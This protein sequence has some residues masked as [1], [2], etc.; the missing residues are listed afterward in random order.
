MRTEADKA[1]EKKAAEKKKAAEEL[2]KKIEEEKKAAEAA[3][4]EQ[5]AEEGGVRRVPAPP[6]YIPEVLGED[7]AWRRYLSQYL[8]RG[9]VED[10]MTLLYSY[11]T[12]AQFNDAQAAAAVRVFAQGGAKRLQHL[13]SIQP[14]ERPLLRPYLAL[15]LGDALWREQDGIGAQQMW[16]QAAKESGWTPLQREARK[17]LNPPEG[18]PA[19]T[20]GLLLPLSGKYEALGRNLLHAAQLAQR[21]YADAGIGLLIRDTAGDVQAAQAAATE[22]IEAGVDAIVGPLFHDPARAAVELAVNSAIPIMPLNPRP[23]LT[24]F[25]DDNPETQRLLYQ[26][27]FNAEQQA[28]DMARY[29]IE[30]DKRR[31]VAIL[32]P[33]S[34]QGRM[35]AEAF[36]DEAK[37][38]GAGVVGPDYFPRDTRDFS[39]W[40][41]QLGH[42]DKE[43]IARRMRTARKA[44]A[45]DPADS[46]QTEEVDDIPPWYAFDALYLPGSAAHGRL[47]APQLAFYD[48]HIPQTAL[49]GAVGWNSPHLL[50]AGAEYLKGAVFPDA[51]EARAGAFH[52]AYSKAWG[53]RPSNLAALAYDAVAVAAQSFRELR[54]AQAQTTQGWTGLLLRDAGFSGALGGLRFGADGRSAR[55][56]TLYQVEEEGIAPLDAP[57]KPKAEAQATT[58][59]QPTSGG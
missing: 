15:A 34:E 56:F 46:A 36:A 11:P 23:D 39:P 45:L 14:G 32:A 38:L 55:D 49:L 20:L 53:E 35:L 6:T 52:A 51:D 40:L 48:I 54:M 41:K 5:P 43:A 30:R 12:D 13:M 17:R 33:D 9:G 42:I 19:I 27:A 31:R 25:D 57:A 24:V 18:K 37:R 47:M 26:N 58:S 21:D 44:Q 8:Q 7:E 50:S 22:L 59:P 1:A 4:A 10:T 3:A 29:A 16:K 28:R 2:A